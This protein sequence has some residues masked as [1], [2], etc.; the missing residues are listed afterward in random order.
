MKKEI[1][2]R[3]NNI[4]YNE[5]IL[6]IRNQFV[7]LMEE[8]YDFYKNYTV[9]IAI[10]QQFLKQEVLEPNCIYMVIKF[11]ST[12]LNYSQSV[13]TGE[14]MAIS[15]ENKLNICQQLL[16]D[17]AKK[18]NL[19]KSMDGSIQ[20]MYDTPTV[21][22]N[23][24][25]VHSGFRSLLAMEFV[26][27]LA[28]T[29]NFYATDYIYLDAFSDA[30]LT[31]KIYPKIKD[32]YSI[33][34]KTQGD[35]DAIYVFEKNSTSGN[36]N[37]KNINSND[38]IATFN[39]DFIQSENDQIYF[40]IIEEEVDMLSQQFDINI[41][42]DSQPFFGTE[43]F[44]KSE[45]KT[46]VLTVGF[47]SYLLYDI[48]LLN[49]ALHIAMKREKEKI[50]ETFLLRLRFRNGEEIVDNFKLISFSSTEQIGD[51]PTANL[52]FTN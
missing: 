24:D 37:L 42:L 17:Y 19:D 15:E 39:F 8:N 10:E 47:S 16:L 50:N 28:V 14:V 25:L 29:A 48:E 7:E 36:W 18:F 21:Q 1:I 30:E 2:E 34:E 49:R 45:A 3:N 52:N 32:Y 13:V 6:M 44:S 46:G 51:I 23:F 31:N 33:Y 40:N 38:I 27:V 9:K 22:E 4:D 11:G 5:L 35:L 43:N 41:S 12:S 26:F 20:Q